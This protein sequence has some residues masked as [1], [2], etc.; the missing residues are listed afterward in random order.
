MTSSRNEYQRLSDAL[1][2]ALEESSEY[3]D[4][5]GA[6]ETLA[7][8]GSADASEAVAE[9]FSSSGPHHHT[10][11]TCHC[12][13]IALSAKGYITEFNDRN[14]VPPHDCGPDGDFRNDAEVNSLVVEVGFSR[15]RA[16]DSLAEAWV[17]KHRGA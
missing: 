2:V 16:L 4:A 14:A 11:N 3:R 15:V 9:I 10:E 1:D 6:M 5:L 7:E 13:C 12:Y 17:C 8:A